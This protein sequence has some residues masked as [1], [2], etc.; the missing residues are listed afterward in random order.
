MSKNFIV[1]F[2]SGSPA[3]ITGFHPTFTVFN[4][5]PGGGATTPPGITEV[6]T[7]TGLYY[8]TYEPL[9]SIAFVID[10]GASLSAA[11]RYIA[12]SLDPVQAVDERISE[13]G[14]TLVAIGN[15][16]SAIA[17]GGIASIGS[18]SDS[19]GSTL[20]DPTTVFGYL[21]R[22]MEFNEGD[23]SFNKS[24]GTWDIFTRGSTYILGAST[25]P[26]LTTMLREK[27]IVDNGSSITKG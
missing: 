17:A 13:M 26:G 20:S 10:G 18:L 21:K 22:L 12:G 2:G 3:L 14:S 27:L 7:S 24:S 16:V 23:S 6:P 9:S 8:F 1:Q 15:T 25:Y 11:A 5:V 4:V 19:Y